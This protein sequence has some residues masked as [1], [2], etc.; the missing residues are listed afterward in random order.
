MFIQTGMGLKYSTS[1]VRHA[2]LQCMN[3]AFTGRNV[4]VITEQGLNKQD[5][6]REYYNYYYNYY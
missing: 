2:Y 3:V 6:N 1:A 5:V 4:S